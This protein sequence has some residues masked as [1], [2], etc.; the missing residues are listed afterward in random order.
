MR[1]DA[2]RAVAALTTTSFR[3]SFVHLNYPILKSH[4][5]RLPR[6]YT[7][8]SPLPSTSDSSD[9]DTV[10]RSSSSPSMGPSGSTDILRDAILS[11]VDGGAVRLGDRMGSKTSVVVLLRHLA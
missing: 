7:S 8:S 9:N 11:T 5:H 2:I 3:T 1:V 6:Y 10:P 4:C